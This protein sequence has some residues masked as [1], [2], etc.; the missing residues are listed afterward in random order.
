MELFEIVVVRAFAVKRAERT[1]EIVLRT[2]P[3][4]RDALAGPFLQR[5]PKG[6][7]RLLQ[8]RRAALAPAERSK[9]I[10]EIVL[11]RGPVE[12]TRSRVLS[13]SAV[14]LSRAERS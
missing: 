6:G 2:G 5:H 13:S 7:E 4:E 10:A 12:R 1:A 8:A 9:R 11:G 3:L 14:P